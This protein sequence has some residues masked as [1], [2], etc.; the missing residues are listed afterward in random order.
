M[1]AVNC[2]I[3]DKPVNREQ[4]HAHLEEHKGRK[5]EYRRY[6]N[7]VVNEP[8]SKMPSFEVRNEHSMAGVVEMYKEPSRQSRNSRNSQSLPHNDLSRRNPNQSISLSR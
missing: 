2:V 3:C 6:D 5:K 7:R 4:F 1:D 8:T